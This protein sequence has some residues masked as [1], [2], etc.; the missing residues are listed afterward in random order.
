MVALLALPLATIPGCGGKGDGDGFHPDDTCHY[1]LEGMGF[2]VYFVSD[3][4]QMHPAGSTCW[5]TAWVGGDSLAGMGMVNDAAVATM[6]GTHLGAS[7]G[8]TLD[9]TTGAVTFPWAP[10]QRAGRSTRSL[11]SGDLPYGN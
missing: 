5:G 2:H 8:Y 1:V 4:A 10:A 11:G 6:S 7:Y 3:P 9:L